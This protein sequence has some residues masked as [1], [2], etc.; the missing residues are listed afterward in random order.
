MG[1]LSD[2][3]RDAGWVSGKQVERLETQERRKAQR[4]LKKQVTAA[5]PTTEMLKKC[6]TI[7]QFRAAAKKLLLHDPTS[8]HE[9][10]P[11]AHTQFK[12]Q[13]EDKVFNYFIQFFYRLRKALRKTANNE[14]KAMIRQMYKK[15]FS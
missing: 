5:T 8:I 11:I 3:L 4:R 15:E 10:I 2:Q 7:Q 12:G 13:I 1:I 14:R 6:S 9:I